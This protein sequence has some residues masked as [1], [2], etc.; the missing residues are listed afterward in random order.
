MA[1]I[2]DEVGSSQLNL[3]RVGVGS[4]VAR[5]NQQFVENTDTVAN[6]LLK[7]GTTVAGLSIAETKRKQ[8]YEGQSRILKAS[9]DGSQKQELQK[10]VN[11]QPYFLSLLGPGAVAEGAVE[12]AGK[13]GA[14]RMFDEQA[15]RLASGQ[16]AEVDP[17]TYKAGIYQAKMCIRDRL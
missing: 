14:G 9:L 17:E 12:M 15:S 16:D 8:F 2:L 6:A 11:E 3:G 4:A 7:I 5:S 1:D 13:V 10:I